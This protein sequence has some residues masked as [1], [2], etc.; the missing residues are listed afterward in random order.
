MLIVSANVEAAKNEKGDIAKPVRGVSGISITDIQ[1][2]G[3]QGG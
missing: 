2:Y 1:K 3:I